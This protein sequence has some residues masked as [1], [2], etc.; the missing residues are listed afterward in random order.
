MA[1]WMGQFSGHTHLTRIQDREMQLRHAIETYRSSAR[2]S[3]QG[4]CWQKII[5][6]SDKLLNARI[7]A[8]KAQIAS[9]DPRDEKTRKSIESKI[10]GISTAGINL[11]L[12][13][14]GIDVAQHGTEQH[15]ILET[16]KS[17]RIG[18]ANTIDEPSEGPE[19]PIRPF[20]NG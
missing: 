19:S 8:L 18:T 11:I 3:E 10:E 7:K 14:F 6:F 15:D 12:H 1:Q 9:L 20:D 13:E 5:K 2:Q 4:A 17:S 16:T